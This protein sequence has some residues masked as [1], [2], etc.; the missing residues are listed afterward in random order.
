VGDRCKQGREGSRKEGREGKAER[1]AGKREK[2]EERVEYM[3]LCKI[4]ITF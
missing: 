4:T 3:K 1:E 2:L